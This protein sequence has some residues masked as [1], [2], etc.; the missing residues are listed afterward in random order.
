MAQFQLQAG[1]DAR[2][3]GLVADR[4]RRPG[5][6]ER[7]AHIEAQDGTVAALVRALI[8]HGLGQGDPR[9]D[10]RGR[11]EIHAPRLG[12][13]D[14]LQDRELRVGVR[15]DGGERC[16]VVAGGRQLRELGRERDPG[17]AG[18]EVDAREGVICRRPSPRLIPP[19]QRERAHELAAI[20][21]QQEAGVA[22]LVQCPARLGL[23]AQDVRAQ[24]RFALC[25]PVI[26]IAEAQGQ[27]RLPQGDVA[28]DLRHGRLRRG[29]ELSYLFPPA[30]AEQG[31]AK[32]ELRRHRAKGARPSHVA[33]LD[34]VAE[35]H[36][37]QHL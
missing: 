20:G 13:G 12:L 14:G 35:R 3:R 30:A 2:R 34:V 7:H 28:A 21:L 16:R 5:E 27:E 22:A 23:A 33:R 25:E 36:V 26:E 37:A 4:P 32:T 29:A 15:D 17:P 10:G 31:I 18:Q 9:F 6:V 8:D 1:L 11:G 24:G 19:R